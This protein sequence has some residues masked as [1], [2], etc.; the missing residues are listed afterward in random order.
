MSAAQI[1]NLNTLLRGRGRGGRGPRLRERG[2]HTAHTN[3]PHSRTLAKD[4][5]IQQTD[6]DASVSR[7]SAVEL[8]YLDD[9]FARAF[10]GNG[11][12][13]GGTAAGRRYPIINRGTYVRTMAI[14]TL[15]SL[16]LGSQIETK[17]TRRKRQI[18]SLGAGSDTRVFRLL[19]KQ[20]QLGARG[21][22]AFVYHELDF[23]TNTAMKIKTIRASPLLLDALRERSADAEIEEDI[24]ISEEGDALHSKYL[25][26]H[27]IDLR[28]LSALPSCETR[29][30]GIDT[31]L[32]TLIISECCLIYLSPTDASNVLSYFTTLFSSQQSPCTP[33]PTDLAPTPLALILYEPIRPHDPFGKTMISNLATRGIHLQ[34]L[35]QYATL[36]LEK[37]RLRDAGFVTGQGAADV[38]FLWEKWVSGEE[39]ERVAGLEMLD[40]IEEWRLL[41]RHY[42]VAWG[43]R[44][45]DGEGG[46]AEQV[47]GA[48]RGLEEQHADEV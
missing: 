47:F 7:L 22:D 8:G 11:N 14:D 3:N 35:S 32:P 2:A 5:V 31:T 41:A 34:T 15:V 1:P 39:K 48:W 29:F 25:H 20:Q 26:I 43:W 33:S 27:P 13:P 9:P 17:C 44:E 42:C 46:G 21:K 12:E 30:K 19:S 38:D 24:S 40:E 18:I 4:K 36:S 10:S 37:D 6:H 23:A 45:T 16:F 28:S